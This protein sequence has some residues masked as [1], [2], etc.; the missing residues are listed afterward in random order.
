MGRHHNI[1]YVNYSAGRGVVRGCLNEAEKELAH[2]SM[3]A[4][5]DLLVQVAIEQIALA[6]DEIAEIFGDDAVVTGHYLFH[7]GK[8][9]V[10]LSRARCAR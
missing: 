6:V 3:K 2:S 7:V 9:P 1:H 4:A 8:H 5:D 10:P